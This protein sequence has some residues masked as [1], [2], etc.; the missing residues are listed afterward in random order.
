MRL[1]KIAAQT[2]DVI[3]SDYQMPDM[4][5]IQFLKKLRGKNDIPFIIFKEKVTGCR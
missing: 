3:V 5:G 2:F 4:D 1:E